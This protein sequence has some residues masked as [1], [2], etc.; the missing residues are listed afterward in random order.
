MRYISDSSYWLYLVHLPLIIVLHAMIR[1]WELPA[2][3]KL[4]LVCSITS[5]LLLVNYQLCV[6]YTPIGTLLNGP[7][8]RPEP[9]TRDE[10]VEA[11]T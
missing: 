5:G 7:R 1:T 8:R 10:V 2:F 9:A 11:A 3:V 6:R 4:I